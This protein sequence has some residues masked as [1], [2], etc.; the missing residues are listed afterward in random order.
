KALAVAPDGSEVF[1]TGF[2]ESCPSYPYGADV[3]TIAYAARTGATSW[4][5]RYNGPGGSDDVGTAVA[6]APDGSKVFVAADSVGT[7]TFGDYAT[8]AYDAHTGATR[9]VRRYAGP[10]GLDSPSAIAVGPG[11]GQVFVTGSSVGP[12]MSAYDYVT[13]SYDASTGATKWFERLSL[14]NN[15]NAYSLAVAPDGSKVFVSGSSGGTTCCLTD[16]GTVAYDAA[17][18]ALVWFHR[19]DGPAGWD[20]VGRSVAVAPDSSRVVV[21]GYSSNGNGADDDI[22]TIAYATSTGTVEWTERYGG[23]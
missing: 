3:A 6:V 21:T 13:I 15:D 19:Y 22:A 18:G 10:N 9:W 7:T 2:S 8:I 11:G 20:D 16:Y 4:V 14:P 5:R 12:S 23:P 17:S 1:V